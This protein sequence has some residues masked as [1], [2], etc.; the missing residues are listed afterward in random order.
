MVG[1]TPETVG[2][3]CL[4]EPTSTEVVVGETATVTAEGATRV[5]VAEP[6]MGGDVSARLVAVTV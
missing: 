3:N 2:V 4:V 6:D 1:V 5:T